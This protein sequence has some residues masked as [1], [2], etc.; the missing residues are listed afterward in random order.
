V[1]LVFVFVTE[2]A[3]RGAENF[4]VFSAS[5]QALACFVEPDLVHLASIYA[6]PWLTMC[7]INRSS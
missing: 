5:L 4:K 6:I 7:R 2:K 3:C 1:N